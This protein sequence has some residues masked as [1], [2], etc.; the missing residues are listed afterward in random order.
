MEPLAGRR[1]HLRHPSET[2]P[3]E[4][5]RR[6]LLHR[7]RRGEEP[8]ATRATLEMIFAEIALFQRDGSS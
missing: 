8:S 3:A 4:P 6:L 2:E 7:G 1:G 5:F